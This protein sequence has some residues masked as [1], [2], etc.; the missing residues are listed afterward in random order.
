[1]LPKILPYPKSLS[2]GDGIVRI[3]PTYTVRGF[4]AVTFAPV[5]AAAADY[6]DRVFGCVPCRTEDG[7]EA[8]MV[9]VRDETLSCHAY[10]ISADAGC[11]GFQSGRRVQ[12]GIHHC[13]HLWSA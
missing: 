10:V 6:F 13:L 2:V 9:F 12:G 5:L 3:A 7:A 1:M 11:A 4:D 8:G